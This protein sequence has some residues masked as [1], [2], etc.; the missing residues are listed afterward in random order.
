MKFKPMLSGKAPVDLST[1]RWPVVVSPKYDG[2]RAIVIDGVV[3]SRSLKPIPNRHVQS[4]FGHL[5]GFDGELIFGSPVADDVFRATT[6]AV[7][8]IDGTPDVWFYVFD[9]IW[10]EMPEAKWLT[11]MAAVRDRVI[12]NVIVVPQTNCFNEEQINK[13]A[14]SYVNEGYEGL[15]IR[16]PL[17]TYKH[18]RSTTKEGTLLK[19]KQFEDSEA[20]V[21]AIEEKLHNAN[22]AKINELGYLSR[23]SHK[24]N[25]VGMKTM[26]ALVVKDLV[27][28]VEFNI[29]TGF[30][31][32]ERARW[33]A[34]GEGA[35]GRL[36]KYTYFPTGSK[37]KPRF[38]TYKGERDHRDMGE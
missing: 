2:V 8:S 10:P 6:S 14:T 7:M 18:G 9:Y 30:D 12:K 27:S 16:N 17:A 36:V 35:K 22:E 15:M 20:I 25:M 29:G 24:E 5:S 19:L 21:L 11:R 4:M 38:P 23:S 28:G 1:L 3:M 26:G 34:L 33:W 32:E 37:D 31:D 13:Y